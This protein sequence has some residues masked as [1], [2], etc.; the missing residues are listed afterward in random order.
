MASR[1]FLFPSY[2]CSITRSSEFEIA[3]PHSF[4]SF[5]DPFGALFVIGLF[6]APMIALSD[7]LDQRNNVFGLSS[8]DLLDLGQVPDLIRENRARNYES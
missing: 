4:D 1:I 2:F 7:A 6:V 3:A 8:G 5:F